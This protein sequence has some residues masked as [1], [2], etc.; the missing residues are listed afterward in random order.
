[1]RLLLVLVLRH[2]Q[3]RRPSW[4]S[5]RPLGLWYHRYPLRC[6]SD[7][8]GTVVALVLQ[9]IGVIAYGVVAFVF[10]LILAFI[11][12]AI[13]GWRVSEEEETEGL[14]AGEH[15]MLAYHGLSIK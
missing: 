2:D 15:G 4:C 9:F 10:A 7:N 11:V 13:F 6:R 3:D 5:V 8:G 1:M 12:K 14:D